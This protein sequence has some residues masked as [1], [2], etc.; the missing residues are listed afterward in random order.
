MSAG[1][2]TFFW[3]ILA[4]IYGFFWLIFLALFIVGKINKSRVL[5]WI[6]GVPLLLSTTFALFF[7]G[8]VVWGIISVSKPSNV[9]KITFGTPPPADV[10]NLQN[11]YWYFADTGSTYLKFKTSPTTIKKLTAN[12]WHPLTGEKLKSTDFE[13]LETD[14]TPSW[15]KPRKTSSTLVYTASMRFDDFANEEETLIYDPVNEQAYY[16]FVGFD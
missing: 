2:V 5:S 1:L 15:W 11:Q 16:E 4:G 6:G 7:L 10:T 3:L 8:T 13:N 12:D 14:D 9:Y